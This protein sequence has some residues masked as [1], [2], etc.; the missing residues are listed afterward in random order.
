MFF[1]KGQVSHTVFIMRRV[2]EGVFR[3]SYSSKQSNIY[4]ADLSAVSFILFKS[5]GV[6][7][8]K[9]QIISEADLSFTRKVTKIKYTVH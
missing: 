3:P 8:P 1:H 9:G 4:A 6:L 2:P 7:Q 5:P